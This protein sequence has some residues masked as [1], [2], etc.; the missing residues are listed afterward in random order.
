MALSQ[1]FREAVSGAAVNV[2]DFD[3]NTRYPVVY[4][5]Q[6]ETKYRPAVC[7]AVMEEYGIIVKVFL[8][9]RY[10]DTFT[11]DDVSAQMSTL[12]NTTFPTRERV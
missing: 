2:S 11:D 10:G 6:V 9:R 3:M 4:C 7:Q 8:P 5:Q 1:K 12:C